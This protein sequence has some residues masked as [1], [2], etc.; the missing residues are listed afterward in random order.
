MNCHDGEKFLKR[1]IDSIISQ[2][3]KNWEIIFFDNKSSDN[4][5]K[6]V[7]RFNDKRIRYFK[8]NKFLNLYNARNLAI[9]R[10]KGRYI[11]FLDTDDLWTKD[12]LQ[13]QLSFLLKNK[14]YKI[15]YSNYFFLDEIK[16]KKEKKIQHIT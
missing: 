9:K 2:T 3:Y 8:S 6:I 10:A 12:K 1:S 11:T 13:T 15:I 5:S 4:S 16:K 14:E 7:K